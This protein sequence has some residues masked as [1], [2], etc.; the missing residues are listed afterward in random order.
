LPLDSPSAALRSEAP[1]ALGKSSPTVVVTRFP[2]G[3]AYVTGTAWEANS[4]S[5]CLHPPHGG[6]G[7]ASPPTMAIASI[8]RA[9]PAIAAATALRSAQTLSGNEL[10][11]TFAAAYTSPSASTAAPTRNPEY[12]A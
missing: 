5:T 11:S 7:R 10:F 12:G 1:N 9:P 3:V 2:A 6:V 4:A 8:R